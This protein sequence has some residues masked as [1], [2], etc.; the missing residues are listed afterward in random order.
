MYNHESLKDSL[1]NVI[2]TLND[3]TCREKDQNG[4][5]GG[6]VDLKDDQYTILV[7]DLHGRYEF[8]QRILNVEV[9]GE[10]VLR[11]VEEKTAQMVCVGDGMHAEIRAHKRWKRA[12]Q[13][14][15]GGFERHDAM[16]EE[17]D[18]NF[19]TMKLVMD[20][21]V[22]FPAQFH[23]LKG[24]H[25]N[26]MDESVNGNHSFAKFAAEG[27]MTR[28]FVEKFYGETFL[29]LWNEFEKMLPLLAYGGNFI[30]SHARPKAF[31]DKRQ[32][33]NYHY[34]PDVIEGMTWTRDQAA[35]DGCIL[36]MMRELINSDKGLWFCGH[37]AIPTL[38]K[39]WEKERMIQFH[40]PKKQVL[41]VIDPG[42]GFSLS[43]NIFDLDEKMVYQ[44]P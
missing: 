6:V 41:V 9:E 28:N 44:R 40:S 33:V 31:Y 27:P 32:L 7:P 30:V 19:K 34:Y 4:Q 16:F 13:E 18:E 14:Y 25:E 12:F 26:I 36:K 10:T 15:L 20:M 23:F 39:Y 11:R 37:T 8:L 38:Y 43:N 3:E 2:A 5:V 17:M 24:N 35:E 22:N 29:N 42:A 21:K 1:N